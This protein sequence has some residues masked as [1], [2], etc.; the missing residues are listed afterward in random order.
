MK[1]INIYWTDMI[2]THHN[3]VHNNEK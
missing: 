1:Y 2:K 3:F